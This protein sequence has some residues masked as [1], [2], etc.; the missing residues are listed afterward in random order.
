MPTANAGDKIFCS[1]N[2]EKYG[3]HDFGSKKICYLLIAGEVYRAVPS[4]TCQ[5]AIVF[6]Q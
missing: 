6:C 1:I 2:I 4:N 5:M 3:S